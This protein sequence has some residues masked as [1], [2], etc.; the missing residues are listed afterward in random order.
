ML[1]DHLRPVVLTQVEPTSMPRTGWATWL[2]FQPLEDPVLELSGSYPS[3]NKESINLRGH[4]HQEPVLSFP[5]CRL[6]SVYLG[7]WD[8]QDPD[9]IP[10]HPHGNSFLSSSPLGWAVQQLCLHPRPPCAG[11]DG[12][13]RYRLGCPCVCG[14]LL[15]VSSAAVSEMRRI[16]GVGWGPR[17]GSLCAVMFLSV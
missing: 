15:I 13:W 1:N 2:Q 17:P 11:C 8:L 7:S 3:W 6:C 16:W 4:G 10:R 14:S 12:T 5:L 9:P